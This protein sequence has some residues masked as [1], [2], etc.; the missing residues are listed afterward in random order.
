MD[1]SDS[2][3]TTASSATSTLP[4]TLATDDEQQQLKKDVERRP[5]PGGGN[6][7]GG[8]PKLTTIHSS[9]ASRFMTLERLQQNMTLKPPKHHPTTTSSVAGNSSGDGSN[10]NNGG[11]GV[12]NN[13]N[14]N[15]TT[16]ERQLTIETA[17]F[18]EQ[19]PIFH[20]EKKRSQA[21]DT[22]KSGSD[23]TLHRSPRRTKKRNKPFTK[24]AEIFAQNLSDA[25]LHAN[26]DSDEEESFVYRD[27][28]STSLYPTLPS[29]WIDHYSKRDTTDYSSTATETKPRR[30]VLRSA[31]SE[32]P[33]TAMLRS[34][35]PAP[36][37]KHS[38]YPASDAD[39]TPLLPR[40]SSSK[41]KRRSSP[42]T[43]K[44]T[45]TLWAIFGVTT[46]LISL[47]ILI[48]SM[49]SPLAAVQVM[50]LSNV[51][52]STKELFFDLHVRARNTNLW[53]IQI[54]HASFSVFASSHYVPISQAAINNTSSNQALTAAP[55]EFLGTIYRFDE[56]L[57]FA[58]SQLTSPTV[59]TATSQ[60]QIKD[61]GKTKGDSSG[62][63]RW[64]L[65]IRYPY[66]LT[67]RGVLK[68]HVIP[69]LPFT[70]MHSARVC[71]VSRI[72]PATGDIHSNPE[73]ER[74]ICDDP[75]PIETIY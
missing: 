19:Q 61:P 40:Y 9:D 57:V 45:I 8:R 49:A 20:H 5:S 59:T 63:E 66:E 32:L 21:S 23:S 29:Q 31:V 51:L 58:S 73:I 38:W 75:S 50:E 39:D 54:S 71:Q 67:V 16:Q 25:V 7:L 22:L 35:F 62:N 11:S 74:S 14:N 72:D 60:I 56:P 30:P 17:V 1:K 44:S 34:T 46:S 10:N 43:S 26:I 36:T 27:Y 53:S 42:R 2:S 52:G 64:S 18:P 55:V 47:W 37:R 65:L 68:Y 33:A 48:I 13:S 69:F 12:H 41:R 70:Q 4:T 28:R 15:N 3:Q 6:R 24:P